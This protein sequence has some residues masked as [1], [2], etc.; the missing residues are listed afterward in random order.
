MTRVPAP[1]SPGYFALQIALVKGRGGIGTA[2]AQYDAMFRANGIPTA[3][4]YEGPQVEALQQA[5]Q[6]LMPV[7]GLLAHPAAS[8]V[9]FLFGGFRRDV[10]R[11]QGTARLIMVVHSDRSLSVLRKLFPNAIIVTPCHSDKV[12]RK[13][14]ANLVVTLNNSQQ[15]IASDALPGVRVA[16]LGNPYA[17]GAVEPPSVDGPVRLNF[18]ARHT[19]IK[20]PMTLLGAAM[21]L[22]AGRCPPIRFFGEGPLLETVKAGAAASGLDITFPGWHDQPFSQFHK[23]D[24]LVLPSR[25]EGLPYLLLEA[26]DHGVPIVASDIA[27]NRAALQDGAFGLLFRAGDAETLASA[28]RAAVSDIDALREKSLSGRASLQGRFSAPAFWSRLAAECTKISGDKHD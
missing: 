7:P 10:L 22:P 5:G 25:W 14:L 21:L 23:A 4:V 15:Q 20:D 1:V 16:M 8:I 28:I 6:D 18:V 19:D 17:S 12:K 11:R 9:S 3:I 13:R 24:I 2:V 27:G 26:M